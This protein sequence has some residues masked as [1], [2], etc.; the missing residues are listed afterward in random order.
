MANK[1]G[2]YGGHGSEVPR[3]L[4]ERD[5]ILEDLARNFHYNHLGMEDAIIT[6]SGVSD[7][8]LDNLVKAL[9]STSYSNVAG[10]ASTFHAG[11]VINYNL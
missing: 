3:M 4:E 9:S 7:A 5:E 1:I 10:P 2:Y 11:Q 6:A 8:V